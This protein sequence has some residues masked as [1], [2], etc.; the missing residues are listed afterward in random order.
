MYKHITN[1]DLAQ[2]RYLNTRM[3][4]QSSSILELVEITA[5]T[6]DS[7]SLQE[8][9]RIHMR[10]RGNS[11]FVSVCVSVCYHKICYVLRLY[12]ENK[13]SILGFFMVL[14]RF[15]SCDVC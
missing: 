5:S 12:V 15:L 8:V 1:S 2:H 6:L 9:C 14:S 4:G 13:V 7:H 11:V 10:H 3:L